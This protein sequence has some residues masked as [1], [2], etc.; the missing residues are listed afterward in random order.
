[1]ATRS[2][3]GMSAAQRRA[4]RRDRL[5]EAT[6][7]VVGSEGYDGLSVAR[8]CRVAGLNDRYFYEHFADRQAAFAALVK[9]L[10]AETLA[11]MIEA[12][13]AAG[14]DPR[15]VVRSGLGACINLLTE[16]PR[17][18]RVVFVESPAHN[19]TAHRSQ[20]RE[21]FIT[22]MRAQAKVQLGGVIPDELEF[23]LK[24]AGIHLFGA[25]MECTTSWLAGDMPISRNELID[26]CTGLLIAVAN[27]TLGPGY[28]A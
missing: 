26:H 9:R 23:R 2:Y 24:F 13:A 22:L 19:S 11:A 16:D 7:D 1:M 21:M 27:Y 8:L 25:L 3:A 5:L 20:I 28:N 10:A 6:L 12:V 15:Q 17:K 14:D 4:E 18:A